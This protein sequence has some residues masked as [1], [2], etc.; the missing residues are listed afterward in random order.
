MGW[1]QD[2][3]KVIV[4]P[5]GRYQ[6]PLIRKARAR[7]FWVV[8]AD[9]DTNCAGKREADEFHVIG[10][11]ESERLLKLARAVRPR[12]IVT[13]QTDSGVSVVAWL[14][15]KLGLPGIGPECAKLFTNKHMMRLFGREHGF[16]TPAFQLCPDILSAQAAAQKIGF[17]VV[18]KPL[19][20]QSS[21][22]IH[23][24][25]DPA[26]L[27]ARFESTNVSGPG[28]KRSANL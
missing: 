13:D 21:R 17:P 23:R 20:S 22:G 2:Q 16:A 5:G 25:E 6:V 28:Q 14:S 15:E 4:L 10:L 24:I 3:G 19:D 18:L 11:N 7:G 12:G 8:C 27:A 9:R 1:R 26:S